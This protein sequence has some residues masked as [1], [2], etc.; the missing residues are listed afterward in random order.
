MA[1]TPQDS[2]KPTDPTT[3]TVEA[4]SQGLMV[5]ALLIMISITASNMRSGSLLHKLILAEVRL[6]LST[7]C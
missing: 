1:T 5:G 6:V 7:C 2:Q 4:W 3:L